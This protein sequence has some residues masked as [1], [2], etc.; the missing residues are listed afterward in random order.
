[1][2]EIFQV[3]LKL[4]ILGF[5]GPLATISMMED[6]CAR[7][8]KW[9]TLDEFSKTFALIKVL[10]GPIAFQMAVYLGRLRAGKLGGVLAA[11]CFTLP[12]FF[13]VL[14][15]G[16]FMQKTPSGP[17]KDGFI[18]GM[19][20]A[21]LGVILQGA[22]RL[23][24]GNLKMKQSYLIAA[25]SMAVVLVR[26]GLEPL[27]IMF[28]GIL[29]ILLSL[30][31]QAKLEAV[32]IFL[33][34]WISL[35]AALLTFG[36]GLAIVPLL[37]NDVVQKFHWLTHSQFLQALAYGQITPG[38]VVITITWIGYQVA[39][40]PGAIAATF[41]IFL[42]GT[43]FA[44]FLIP[45]VERRWGASKPVT[46]FYSFV[47]PAVVGSMFAV[48][49][50]LIMTSVDDPISLSVFITSLVL[51]F[52]RKAPAWFVIPFLGIVSMAL[53]KGEFLWKF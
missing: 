13:F 49:A 25:I 12:S 15:L 9:C 32:S 33:I 45:F 34:V 11:L 17:W 52:W 8:R 5:G 10:P 47:I 24:S 42:P 26:P 29:G 6:E 39:Q 40:L 43:L 46:N 30:R 1:M 53:T 4:G 31:P 41:F 7:K 36:S 38:P 44:L 35:K 20:V 28:F 18:N 2:K 23:A 50:K 3:F 22:W 51:V 21:A 19:E 37:E 48:T 27:T 16:I 14:I